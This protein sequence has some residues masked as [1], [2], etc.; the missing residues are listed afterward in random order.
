MASNCIQVSTTTSPKIDADRIARVLLEKK[1]AACVQ[2]IGPMTST[3]WW[4]GSIEVAKEWLCLI[5]TES[6][7]Y[8]RVERTIRD[9]H[10]YKT[11]EIVAVPIVAGSKDYM[12]WLL[13]S[14]K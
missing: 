6:S 10:T 2:V 14:L 7:L 11:P 4:K 9:V 3:Y 8:R 12:K 1:L 13:S 5:K